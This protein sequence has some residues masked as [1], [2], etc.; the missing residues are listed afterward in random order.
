MY[1]VLDNE[2]GSLTSRIEAA[3]KDVG[4]VDTIVAVDTGGDALY[5]TSVSSA[6]KA[7]PDQDL[8]VLKALHSLQGPRI[9][10]AEIAVGVD[11]PDNASEVLSK[12]KAKLFVPSAAESKQIA[13]RYRA[14]KLDGTDDKLFGKTA[15]AWQSALRGES[16]LQTLP[17]P[18]TVVV[19][20]NKTPWSPFVQIDPAMRGV[21]FMELDDHLNAIGIATVPRERPNFC[22]L[23]K[24]LG[25]LLE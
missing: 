4:G 21:F 14:W 6:A 17:L 10:T 1:L 7:T 20:P 8:R 9:I 2:D 22:N 3:L 15:L 13:D 25:E 19:D 23:K 18:G 12:G 5:S 11:S 16:G 24:A